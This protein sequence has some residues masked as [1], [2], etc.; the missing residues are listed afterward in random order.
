M[1]KQFSVLILVFIFSAPHSFSQSRNEYR[2]DVLQSAIGHREKDSLYFDYGP[3]QPSTLKAKIVVDKSF[4]F[5]NPL[6]SLG[7][8]NVF[9]LGEKITSAYTQDSTL[10]YERWHATD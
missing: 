9:T 8:Y 4:T 10:F 5:W 7:S 3:W 6:D 1:L 2:Y